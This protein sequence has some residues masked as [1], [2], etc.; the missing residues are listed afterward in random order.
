LGR[1]A[2]A[3]GGLVCRLDTF[4]RLSAVSFDLTMV[5]AISFTE[6]LNSSAPA[7]TLS[8]ICLTCSLFCRAMT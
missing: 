6:E 5:S 8:T 3:V 7:A 2:E 4:D 1:R